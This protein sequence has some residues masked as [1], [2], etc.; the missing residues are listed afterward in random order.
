MKRWLWSVVLVILVLIAAWVIVNPLGAHG[1][2][3][4]W[5]RSVGPQPDD[6]TIAI[7]HVREASPAVVSDWPKVD[8]AT[9]MQ[10]RQVTSGP[11]QGVTHYDAPSI[12]T[13]GNQL[14]FTGPAGDYVWDSE[15]TTTPCAG[16]FHVEAGQT[17]TFGPLTVALP[18]PHR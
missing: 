13:D 12:R 11:I 2:P 8:P 16:L 17:T 18:H 7:V 1:L 4:G 6:C 10:L 3:W 5:G 9:V 15:E 14:V